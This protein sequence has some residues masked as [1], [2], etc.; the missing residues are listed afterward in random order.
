M[1][2]DQRF[3]AH[4]TPRLLGTPIDTTALHPWTTAHGN[5]H[6]AELVVIT[7]LSTPPPAA[8]TSRWPNPY[9]ADTAGIRVLAW[10]NL[11]H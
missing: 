8:T 11:A 1:T 4:T 9:A 7:E 10:P 5:F 3:L 6:F 2:I